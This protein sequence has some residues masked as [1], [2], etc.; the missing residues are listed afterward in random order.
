MRWLSI[1]RRQEGETAASG[2]LAA[3]LYRLLRAVGPYLAI[4]L[5]LP[6]GSV[7]ALLLWLHRRLHRSA[8]HTQSSV[9]LGNERKERNEDHSYWRKW[10]DRLKSR[11]EAL[12]AWSSRRAGIT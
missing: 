4:E 8:A 3:S 11:R 1:L 7:I 5:L 12:R 10:A 6:G 9:W 2:T